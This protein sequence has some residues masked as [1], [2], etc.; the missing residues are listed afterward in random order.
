MN[1][2]FCKHGNTSPAL[3][4]F[5]INRGEKIIVLKNIQADVCDTCGEQFLS[6]DTLKLIE[7]KVTETISNQTELEVLN[8]AI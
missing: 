8:M 6:N 5:S 3:I 4:N 7:N 2:T 1:C